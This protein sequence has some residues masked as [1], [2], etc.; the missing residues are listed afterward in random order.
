M[1]RIVFVSRS[2]DVASGGGIGAYVT[3][4]ARLLAH[5]NDVTVVAPLASRGLLNEAFGGTDVEVVPLD[6]ETHGNC[7]DF[8]SE[9]HSW[10]A[11]VWKYVASTAARHPIDYIE[12]PDYLGEGAV[13]VQ[14]K[15]TNAKLLRDTRIGVRAYTTAE[16]CAVLDGSLDNSFESTSVHDL[17]RYALARADN[18]VH[19]GGDIARTYARYYGASRVARPILVRHPTGFPGSATPPVRSGPLKILYIGRLERRKGV[20]SLIDGLAG[21]PISDWSLTLVGGDTNTGPV[22]VS[23]R[24]MIERAAASDP[25]IEIR[26]RVPH[27]EI[28]SLIEQHDAVIVPSI[29]E[30]WPNTALEAFAHNRPVLASPVGGLSEMVIEGRSGMLAHGN[31]RDDL[32]D[33]VERAVEHTDR[34]REMADDQR[35]L[36]RFQELAD[37]IE[38][39]RDYS[40][41][42]RPVEQ[43]TAARRGG[44]ANRPLVTIIVPYFK[45]RQFLPD[46][47][48]S[49]NAQTH[50]P[51]ETLVINDGSF[52]EGDSDLHA[53]CAEFGA[54]VVTK[55]NGG[56]GSA[57]NFGVSQA[58]G[59]FIV[60]LDAD[61]MLEPTFV[62]RA[63]DTLM[64]DPELAFVSS[65]STYVDD[66]D[67]PLGDGRGY[68][69]MGN[70][71]PGVERGN[72]AGD[73]VAAIRR[74]VFDHGFRY[75][76]ELVSF[77][78]WFLYRQLHNSGWFGEVIPERLFRYRVREDSM[79]KSDGV[80]NLDRIESEMNAL[81][82]DEEMQW[83]S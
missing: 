41:L 69:A 53:L 68:H 11:A 59:E 10:S 34:L 26:G 79:L 30:C 51:L 52:S 71:S 18:F 46:T 64:A 12:F 20:Y 39:E 14:A 13:T 63:I 67:I 29:W 82:L 72:I 8:F 38:V 44:R 73:A 17:E 50:R 78:D 5:R 36:R 76:E 3:A 22:D 83:T 45:L 61:N 49:I 31:S 65:W 23:M 42:A 80:P 81:V 48:A 55:V 28:G 54:R 40:E 24:S 74:D 75:S 56:L 7:N 70:F 57:R 6:Y 43:R 58:R 60:P 77:E 25:R 35:P 16:M 32:V 27:R 2:I 47:L 4:Q 66:D 21:S 9:P 62:E 37:P 1:A 33:L 15:R 19:A